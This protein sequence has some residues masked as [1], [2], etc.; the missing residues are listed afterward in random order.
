MK[1]QSEKKN[2][3][4]W[5][6]AMCRNLAPVERKTVRVLGKKK[7]YY[8]VNV[9][10][11]CVEIIGA[12]MKAYP[13]VRRMNLVFHAT[14]SLMK[15]IQW[16]NTLFLS[17]NYPLVKARLRFNWELI[18]RAHFI[19]TYQQSDPKKP[20]TPGPT[21]GEKLEWWEKY[22]K[23]LNWRNCLE[24]TLRKVLPLAEK[25]EEVRDFYH[26]RLKDLHRYAHP[27]AYL[28]DRLVGESGL[29]HKDNVDKEWAIDTLNAASVV[30]DVIWLVVLGYYPDAGDRLFGKGLLADY[31][32]VS[33]VLKRDEPKRPD[34]GT[35][36]V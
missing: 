2:S 17:G 1:K 22:E 30:F 3:E 24:P 36:G 16:L 14:T 34:K 19:E 25:V 23:F 27:S 12:I 11:D 31:P 4:L 26:N 9:Y 28:A 5:V 15:E 18:G 13:E 6:Q 29:H 8:F 21:F 10:L 32:V 20:P 35:C 7:A 33:M